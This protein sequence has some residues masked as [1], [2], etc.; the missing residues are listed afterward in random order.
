MIFAILIVLLPNCF[1][2]TEMAWV[3]T[4]T[5]HAQFDCDEM[6]DDYP[7]SELLSTEKEK[8]KEKMKKEKCKKKKKGQ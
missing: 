4:G 7:K 1:L 3:I 5:T 2:L 6:P 8:E